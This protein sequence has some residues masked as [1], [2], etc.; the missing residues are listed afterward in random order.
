MS[1]LL[2][3]V[4]VACLLPCTWEQ[5]LWTSEAAKDVGIRGGTLLKAAVE[6]RVERISP[7]EAREIF[8]PFIFQL[9]GMALVAPSCFVL[10]YEDLCCKVA[11]ESCV[12]LQ[13]AMCAF[14]G[15]V[16]YVL[17]R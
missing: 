8:F 9:L 14:T 4:Y 16:I 1:A 7:R 10:M 5:Y 13:L 3:Q 17:N 6:R 11:G 12:H 2:S 15:P